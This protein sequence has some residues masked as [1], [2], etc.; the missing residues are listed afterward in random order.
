MKRSSIILL[1]VVVLVGIVLWVVMTRTQLPQAAQGV[2]QQAADLTTTG[3][4][5]SNFSLSKRL[6]IYDINVNTQNGLVTLSGRVPTEIDK[7][8]AAGVA[9]D[10]TGVREVTNQLIVE[11]GIRPSEESL[12]ENARIADL[13]IQADL[14]ERF[15]SSPELGQENIQI[16]VKDKQITLSGEVTSPRQKAGAEQ[17]ARSLNNVS[18]VTN[19]LSIRHPEAG[20]NE[21]PGV[22]TESAADQALSQQVQ[23]ALFHERE[24]FTDRKTK[25]EPSH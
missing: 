8:L 19:A 20:R 4:V 6:S 14:R 23:F 12:R 22:S 13:E 2:M 24:S 11:P 21:T 25:T 15:A 7:D 10:T 5:K 9:K 16:A 18:G 3:K 17:V 1:I